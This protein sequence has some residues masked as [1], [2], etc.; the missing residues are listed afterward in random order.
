M[1][2]G[3][4]DSEGGGGGGNGGGDG[5]GGDGGGGDGGGDGG[6]GDGG[7]GEG[8]GGDGGGA[9]D[10]GGDGGC[11]DGGGGGEGG[12]NG[13]DPSMM[14]EPGATRILVIRPSLTALSIKKRSSFS[15]A[16]DTPFGESGGSGW[17]GGG[18]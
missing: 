11:G 13:V 17:S 6:G 1:G 7:G 5:G 2:G 9:G 14:W 4:G 15:V 8:G 12:G 16:A 18:A 3:T 10:G